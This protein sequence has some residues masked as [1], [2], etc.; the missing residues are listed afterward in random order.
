[1]EGNLSGTTCALLLLGL[2]L[3][4]P[5]QERKDLEYHRRYVSPSGLQYVLIGGWQATGFA[6]YAR[7]AGASAMR[8]LPTRFTDSGEA[9]PIA[10]EAGDHLLATGSTDVLPR[11]VL[12]PDHLDGF[13]LF[14]N[15]RLYGHGVTWVDGTGKVRF[16]LSL[17]DLFAGK[18][19][20][21]DPEMGALR[22]CRECWLDEKASSILLL[23]LGAEAR[24]VTIPNGQVTT[25]HPR[26]LFDLSCSATAERRSNLLDALSRRPAAGLVEVAPQVEQ[27]FFGATS[28]IELRLRAGALLARVGD[29][30]LHG[31]IQQLFRDARA[32]DQPVEVRRYAVLRLG[33]VL[34]DEA[35][36]TLRQLL[37]GEDPV[38]RAA[39]HGAFVACGDHAVPTLVEMLAEGEESVDYRSCA[40]LSLCAIVVD[41]IEQKG[42]RST[43][44]DPAVREALFKAVGMMEYSVAD[45][46]LCALEW[47]G[48][49]DLGPRLI[50]LLAQGVTVDGG[51]AHFLRRHP[52]SAALPAIEAALMRAQPDDARKAL[53][54]ARESCAKSTGV[55]SDGR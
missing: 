9:V 10:P 25:P 38:V 53:I 22:W 40:A 50:A 32:A 2:A 28:P 21:A 7:A 30:R 35:V 34:G 19:K 24:E 54:L 29:S 39:C 17:G 1:M 44:S 5:A 49:D 31:S 12:V 46:A 51:I 33:D 3:T 13:L 45:P 42:D 14:E 52:T 15:E 23:T 6:L 18:P 48:G 20:G 27:T 11:D 36:D 41:A 37:R 26:R 4:A 55:K 47:I 16:S 8:P 43:V